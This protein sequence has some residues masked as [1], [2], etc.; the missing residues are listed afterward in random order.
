MNIKLKIMTFV[1]SYL[2]GYKAGG[3]IRTLANIVD[4]LGDEF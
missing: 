3:P 2:P 1:G 4:R